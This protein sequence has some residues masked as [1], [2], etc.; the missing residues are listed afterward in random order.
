MVYD[1]LSVDKRLPTF[2]E[3]CGFVLQGLSSRHTLACIEPEDE[4]AR[5]LRNAVVNSTATDTSLKEKIDPLQVNLR[6]PVHW[7]TTLIAY[8]I[9]QL[10]PN[11]VTAN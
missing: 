7:I 6:S 5:L 2:G 4:C 8:L 1:I 9:Q 10:G 11:T 3:F